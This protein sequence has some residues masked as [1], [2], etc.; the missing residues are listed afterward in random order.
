VLTATLKTATVAKLD[1]IL[2]RNPLMNNHRVSPTAVKADLP[3]QTRYVK[4]VRRDVKPATPL[5]HAEDAIK[6]SKK[7]KPVTAKSAEITVFTA[8]ITC[9]LSALTISS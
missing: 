5:H 9:A 7:P 3:T 4:N 6:V 2:I 1:S 8:L